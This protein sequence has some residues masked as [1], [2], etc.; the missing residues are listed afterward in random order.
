VLRGGY[1]DAYRRS[2]GR[3]RAWFRSYVTGVLQRDVRDLANIEGLTAM[4]R[5][6]T[7]LAGRTANLL[8]TKAISSDL[9]LP[10]TT[11]QRYMTLLETTYLIRTIRTYTRNVGSRITKA[12]KLMFVDT[13][14]AAALVNLSSQRL[15]REP[16][17]LGPLVENFVAVELGK[18][19][20]WHRRAPEL[21]YFRTA[22][23]AEV[24][25]VIEVEGRIVGV[26]VKARETVREAD[27]SGLETLAQTVRSRFH[28][29]VLLYL[30]DRV[31]PFGKRLHAVP[32]SALWKW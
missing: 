26:E 11:L 29:G 9:G 28:R 6:L 31:L 22:R 20:S 13:G 17:L 15:A 16:D 23:G 21:F 3:R 7:L 25:L 8:N 19:A 24:D 12:P 27:F 4:P 2:E 30:G 10:Y 5:L 14:L 18:Q 1:P 32:V